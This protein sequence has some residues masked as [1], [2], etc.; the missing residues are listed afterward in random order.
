MKRLAIGMVAIALM[1]GI[2]VLVAC[3]DTSAEKSSVSQNVS[4][5]HQILSAYTI[6]RLSVRGSM[7]V[8]VFYDQTIDVT[9]IVGNPSLF[10]PAME[11]FEG[12]RARAVENAR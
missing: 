8:L 4:E 3:N 5:N 1:L 12:N 10:Y 11:C 7:D 6:S 9:C 2:T